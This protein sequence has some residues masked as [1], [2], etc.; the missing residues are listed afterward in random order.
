MLWGDLASSDTENLQHNESEID[1][2][3]IQ[4]P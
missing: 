4:P 2:G 1:L 3:E